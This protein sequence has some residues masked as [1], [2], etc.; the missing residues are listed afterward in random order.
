VNVKL[1]SFVVRISVTPRWTSLLVSSLFITAAQAAPGDKIELVRDLAGRVGP[2]IG[3]ALACPDVTRPR[4]QAVIEKFAAVIRDAASNEAQRSDLAQ[5][6]DRS[7]ADGRNAVSTG[8]MDCI[9]AERRLAD[10][11]Q[12]LAPSAPPP[13][14]A[15]PVPSLAPPA[16]AAPSPLPAPATSLGNPATAV[17]GVSDS[18]IRFGITAAFTGPVRE[19]GR[20]MKLGIETAFNQINDAGGIAGRKLRIIAADDGNEPTRTLQAVRQLYEKDQIFGIIGSIGTATAA[21]AVPFALERRMLFFGAY[22]GGNVVRRDPPDRYVFNYRPSYAEEADAAVRYLV[23]LRKIPIRQI[24]VFAQTDDLGDAGYAGVAKAYRAM[25]LN[26]NAILRLNYPRNTI[27]VDEAVNTLRAQKVPVRAI[28]MS[29]SYRA[30]AKFIEKTRALFPEMIFTSISGVGGSSLAE[31]LKL[32]GPRYTTGVLVTQVV[33]AV[34]GYSSAVLEYK[35]ALAKYFPG[36]APDYASLEGFVAANILI[37]ALKRV[38]PQL[39]T[40]KLV[41]TLESTRN[42]DLGLGVSLNFGRSEHTAS[43]KIWGTALDESGRFQ[44]VELE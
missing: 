37:D 32:L 1:K 18:E 36:E 6:F 17:R 8:R 19:R 24:A 28:I 26:D 43:K 33:P 14:A 44:A 39:D 11:E 15:V 16:F 2:V 38:G 21:V 29:A 41:D 20:Q 12:S 42:L 25:G 5:Q 31:E 35:N 34:S 3:S 10:L 13:T 4:V 9:Q 23:K 22:T 7:V 40:E 30:A 27:E